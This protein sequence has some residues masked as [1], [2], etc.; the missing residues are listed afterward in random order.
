MCGDCLQI[1]PTIEKE[2][3]DV[4]VC[5]PPYNLKIHYHEYKDD[6]PY[7]DYLNWIFT[8][9]TEMKRV[10][11]PDGSLF[12]NIGSTSINPWISFD[13]ANKIREIL[14]LQ[15]NIIWIKA[16]TIDKNYGHIK[17]KPR[18]KR[19]LNQHHENIFHFT[20]NG[21]I[22]IDRDAIS[23]PFQ[24]TRVH[25]WKYNGES[26]IKPGYRCRGNTWYLPYET[27]EKRKSH[28]AGFPVQLPELCIKMV[29][30]KE[31]MLVLD[32]FMGAG[33]TLV[34]AKNLKVKGIGIE[35]DKTYCDIT[36]DRLMNI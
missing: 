18:S 11:K 10:L 35:I 32:P 16:I 34:A 9:S 1:L 2:F 17:P 8:V 22:K 27:I 33:S 14:C 6:M 30:I 24:E 23:V 15:N 21:N 13:V 3:V 5:S 29:G 31:N 36:K 19:F 26:G 12:L 4:I 28:P 7:Q 20:K 25:R